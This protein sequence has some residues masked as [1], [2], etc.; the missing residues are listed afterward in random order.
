MRWACPGLFIWFL[1]L[2]AVCPATAQQS[3]TEEIET[4]LACHGDS[5][6]SVELPSGEV[7]SLY[8]DAEAFSS[9]VHGSV[10]SCTNCHTDITEVPHASRPF[11]TLREFSLAYYEACKSCHFDNYTKLLDSVHYSS[12]AQGNQRAPLCVDCHGAHATAA[13]DQSRSQIS[14][15]CSECHADIFAVYRESVHG[16][17]LLEENNQDVPVCTDC[18]RSHDI[19]DPRTWDWR[20][21]IPQL[22]G[23]CHG[24]KELMEKYGFSRDVFQSYLAD[25]HGMIASLYRAEKTTPTTITA[26]CT[27]CHGI[28]DI[29]SVQE[30]SSPVVQANLAQ[31]CQQCHPDAA[32]NFPSAWLSHY[33]PSWRHA[34]LVYLVELFYMIFIPFVIG[35]LVLQVG[36]NLWRVV[37][38][39]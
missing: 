4:C 5:S 37:V 25:F 17:A 30:P 23:N 7:R 14:K 21:N 33:E 6:L 34:R 12:L 8:I 32:E 11:Q 31:V 27:D 20:L 39:R 24:N 35:G 22:C 38:N 15:T 2:A 28:H 26:L 29:T 1:V 10:L 18:H 36:L 16:R 3:D 13:R 19:A 9:S